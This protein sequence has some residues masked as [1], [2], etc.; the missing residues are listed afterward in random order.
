[1]NRKTMVFLSRSFLVFVVA[2]IGALALGVTSIHP[3]W[4]DL[5]GAL[6]LISILSLSFYLAAFFM[7]ADRKLS[8]VSLVISG[9]T[10]FAIATLAWFAVSCLLT[11][12][13]NNRAIAM[14]GLVFAPV[15]GLFSS[16][17]LLAIGILPKKRANSS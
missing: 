12:I 1:M 2:N 5:I 17:T 9:I 15:M 16:S 4:L 8:A 13:T 7:R 10:G 14:L 11:M 3:G 6:G